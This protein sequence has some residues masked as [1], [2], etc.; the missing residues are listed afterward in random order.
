MSTAH[1][2]YELEKFFEVSGIKRKFCA[3]FQNDVLI[4]LVMDD[5]EVTD[6]V[7]SDNSDFCARFVAPFW[8]ELNAKKVEEDNEKA[9]NFYCGLMKELSSEV[10]V[11]SDSSSIFCEIETELYI[12]FK[13]EG[14]IQED[15]II[16]LYDQFFHEDYKIGQIYHA[17]KDFCP[18]QMIEFWEKHFKDSE[19]DYKQDSYSS[20]P[21]TEKGLTESMFFR[22]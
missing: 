13:K 7:T 15:F 12:H 9:V 5:T 8:T 10:F 4:K 19:E 2:I 14:E 3:S 17:D 6:F 1:L 20:D 18:S 16:E 21:Y 11:N 22:G